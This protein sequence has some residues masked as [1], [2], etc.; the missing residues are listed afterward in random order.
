MALTICHKDNSHPNDKNYNKC[1]A[2]RAD[3]IKPGCW[4]LL[5]A[6]TNFKKYP[7]QKTKN[8]DVYIK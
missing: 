6:T 3:Q 2:D 8:E 1:E 7:A 5:V 4:I